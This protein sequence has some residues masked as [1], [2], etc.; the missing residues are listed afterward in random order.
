MPY[1]TGTKAV[2]PKKVKQLAS[3]LHLLDCAS[4]PFRVLVVRMNSND[5]PLDADDESEE[6]L[7]HL[8][9][10]VFTVEQLGAATYDKFYQHLQTFDPHAVHI[11]GHGTENGLYFKKDPRSEKR[12]HGS[13]DLVAALKNSRHCLL[14]V[15]NCCNSQQLGK[16]LGTAGIPAVVSTLGAVPDRVGVSFGHVYWRGISQGHNLYEAFDHAIR[17]IG[18]DIYTL[19]VSSLP[20]AEPSPY[21]C[22]SVSFKVKVNDYIPAGL[23]D[24]V[25]SLTSCLFAE[26]SSWGLNHLMHLQEDR[27]FTSHSLLVNWKTKETGSSA[28]DRCQLLLEASLRNRCHVLLASIKCTDSEEGRLCAR[29]ILS[30]VALDTDS[31]IQSVLAEFP[32]LTI[33]QSVGCPARHVLPADHRPP[34]ILDWFTVK[35]RECDQDYNLLQLYPSLSMA[36]PDRA[37]QRL[38]TSA[39][40]S[41]PLSVDIPEHK[42]PYSLVMLPHATVSTAWAAC[43]NSV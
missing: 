5:K 1:A 21:L 29:K 19:N 20:E 9:S 37:P 13:E 42:V 8:K 6:I 26:V 27:L 15:L 3:Q 30:L 31:V 24:R 17:T 11:I 23:V 34:I 25:L 33:E 12:P 10:E 41:Q 39:L 32:G 38:D 16:A 4:R 2:V 36:E 22:F 35:C 28:L 40:V 18:S 43:S 7:S 14:V